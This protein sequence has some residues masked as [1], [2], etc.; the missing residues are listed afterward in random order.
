MK[1]KTFDCVESKNLAQQ[2]IYQE[3]DKF[4]GEERLAY[5][6]TKTLELKQKQKTTLCKKQL[7]AKSA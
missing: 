2:S 5:Y 1:N 6:H 7:T 3:T 4:S